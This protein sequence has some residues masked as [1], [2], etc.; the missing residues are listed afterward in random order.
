MHRAR[1]N[2]RCLLAMSLAVSAVL[3]G[4]NSEQRAKAAIAE[5]DA[6]CQA[7]PVPASLGPIT[8]R[9]VYAD[10]HALTTT[11]AHWA[12]GLMLRDG[13]DFVESNA[14]IAP[15]APGTGQYVRFRIG[16]AG[17]A[18]CLRYA[19]RAPA[20]PGP[21]R[22]PASWIDLG[23]RADECLA[24][25]RVA[26]LT[27]EYRVTVD[28]V[29]EGLPD[30]SGLPMTQ[31]RLRIRVKNAATG[32]VAYELARGYGYIHDA[33]DIPFGCLR[34]DEMRRMEQGL[35]RGDPSKA[36]SPGGSVAIVEPAEVPV[37]ERDPV[38]ESSTGIAHQPTTRAAVEERQKRSQAATVDGFD[39]FLDGASELDAG[40]QGVVHPA[41]KRYLEWTSE[42]TY[43]RTRMAWLE[44]QPYGVH[45]RPIRLYDL[46][47]RI[48]V[49]AV[50]WQYAPDVRDRALLSW[51]EFSRSN[52][53]LVRR[54]QGS[55]PVESRFQV[56]GDSLV[57]AITPIDGGLRF[58]VAEVTSI[59]PKGETG[60]TWIL[61]E[62]PYRWDFQASAP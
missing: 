58:T 31:H 35:F 37:L 51:A 59:G 29:T 6:W 17:E 50:I 4:C 47:D 36:R 25:E 21:M 46:G 44:G 49:L 14:S 12:V 34:L 18:T 26:S 30:L 8:A 40:N 52:G 32:E 57:E 53:H 62:T 28:P 54:V 2:H 15:Q 5:T 45:E 24:A 42:G 48:G 10:P 23:L 3:Q 19:N 33:F 20:P 60:G 9:S 56:A 1:R 11:A 41:W 55:F 43:V 16:K 61:R 7:N 27:S 39:V 38:A 13:V 22:N